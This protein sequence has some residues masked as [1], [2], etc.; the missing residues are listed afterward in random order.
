[1]LLGKKISGVNW[2]VLFKL[3]DYKNLYEKLL[4][5]GDYLEFLI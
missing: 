1:M 3:I 5:L 4:N 2:S